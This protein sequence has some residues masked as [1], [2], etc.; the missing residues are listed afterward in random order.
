MND[1]LGG[2]LGVINPILPGGG[3][4]RPFFPPS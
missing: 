2:V 3:F 4:R 1:A